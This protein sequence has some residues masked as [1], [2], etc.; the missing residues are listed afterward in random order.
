MAPRP[1]TPDSFSGASAYIIRPLGSI[2]RRGWSYDAPIRSWLFYD[3]RTG[4][5]AP[6]TLSEVQ[7]GGIVWIDVSEDVEFK[8]L[9]LFQGWNLVP[10][11]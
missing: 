3:P 6:N 1:A 7:S 2:S 8:S 11:P 4:F 5:A 9:S 10:L